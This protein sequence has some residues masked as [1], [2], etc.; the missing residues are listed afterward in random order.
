MMNQKEAIASL[1]RIYTQE[2]SLAEEAKDIKDEAKE[3]GL[4][5][6]I[7]SAVAKAIVKNKVDDLKA[8]S[9]EILKAI[10]VSR[11]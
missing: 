10:E 6:A 8:K 3:S 4:D 5:P 7:I 1:V 9:G 11:S 2:Q